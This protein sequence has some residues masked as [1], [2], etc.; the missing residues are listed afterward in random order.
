MG[1]E[2]KIENFN[3]PAFYGPPQIAFFQNCKIFTFSNGR[4]IQTGNFQGPFF[5]KIVVFL[6]L[7]MNI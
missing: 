2:K 3:F 7:F 6:W 5:S 4:K 1:K